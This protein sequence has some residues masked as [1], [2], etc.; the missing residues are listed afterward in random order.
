MRYNILADESADLADTF[1]I[2]LYSLYDDLEEASDINEM[3]SICSFIAVKQKK[4]NDEKKLESCPNLILR[5]DQNRQL[6]A[7]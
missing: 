2:T 4:L 5:R 7:I 3:I 6:I 1:Y